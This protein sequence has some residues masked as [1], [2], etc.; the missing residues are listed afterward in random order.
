VGVGKDL[1]QSRNSLVLRPVEWSAV[2]GL[3]ELYES[4]ELPPG[5]A[6]LLKLVEA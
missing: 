5:A 3:R 1:G 4:D 2:S 6:E